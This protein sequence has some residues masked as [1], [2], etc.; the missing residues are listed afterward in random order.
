MG[1]PKPCGC[2][3]DRGW[4]LYNS[5]NLSGTRQWVWDHVQRVETEIWR[6]ASEDCFS[7]VL[8]WQGRHHERSHL[9]QL[10]RQWSAVGTSQWC[11]HNVCV[12]GQ[13]N[14]GSGH[15]LHLAGPVPIALQRTIAVMHSR[16]CLVS[17]PLGSLPI[18]MQWKLRRSGW[19]SS[20]MIK[21][22]RS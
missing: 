15:G 3:S 11:A 10:Q 9:E 21:H 5:L 18:A 14:C 8:C 22:Y 1:H 7:S 20:G 13:V 12:A 6:T 4:R 17:V 19:H 16:W 2:L